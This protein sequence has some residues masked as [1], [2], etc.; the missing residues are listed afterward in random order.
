MRVS[1]PTVCQWRP[2]HFQT[3]YPRVNEFGSVLLGNEGGVA[4]G[5]TSSVDW[6]DGLN[7]HEP[8]ILTMRRSGVDL[9]KYVVVARGQIR[10]GLF[11]K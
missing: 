10:H 9:V 8:K 7:F 6:G 4:N 2:I 5:P 11:A 3:A 1:D